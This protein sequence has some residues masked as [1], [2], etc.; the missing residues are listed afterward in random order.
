MLTVIST[1]L[2][3]VVDCLVKNCTSSSLH[4]MLVMVGKLFRFV[5]LEDLV[6]PTNTKRLKKVVKTIKCTKASC[7]YQ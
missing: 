5:T 6:G 2:L 7:V 4:L 1:A 3:I